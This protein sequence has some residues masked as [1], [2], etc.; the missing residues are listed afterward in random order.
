[1]KTNQILRVN[2]G[3]NVLSIGHKDRMGNLN[4]LVKIANDYRERKGLT[5][6]A[7][8]KIL[9]RK[10]ISEYIL[11]LE[12]KTNSNSPEMAHL[13]LSEIKNVKSVLKT[14]KGKYGGTWADL[15]IMIRIAIDLDPDFADEVITTFIEGKLLDFRDFAGDD[16]KV[17]S[18]SLALFQPTT[19]QRIQMA[20]GLNYI[21]FNKH[22]SNIRNDAN[23]EQLHE[24]TDIQKKLA[25]AVDMRYI[26]SF[27]ELINEMRRMWDIKWR[28][29]N[30]RT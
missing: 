7:L 10:A 12:N 19:F 6:I 23:K 25:F 27:D 14:K 13:E 8:D 11:H 29:L 30:E 18:S 2:F 4:E 9:K 26:R 3:K 5:R 16:F 20:K 24:L 21:V 1:M 15:N 22:Y 28:C 17:L